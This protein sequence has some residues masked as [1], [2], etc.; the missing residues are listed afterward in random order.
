MDPRFAEAIQIMQKDPQ[1]FMK[2]YGQNPEFTEFL[3]EFSG[4]MANHFNKL[5]EDRQSQQPSMDKEVE[6]IINEPKV[7]CIIE[8]LQKEGKIDMNEIQ[9]DLELWA[10][11]KILIDKGFIKLQRE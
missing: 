9:R 11:L 2:I 6:K 3:K 1:K 10:K 7:K 4:L 5:G 8:R